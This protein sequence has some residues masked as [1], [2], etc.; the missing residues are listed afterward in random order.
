MRKE[1]GTTLNWISDLVMKNFGESQETK[2][3]ADKLKEIPNLPSDQVM[4][5]LKRVSD[6]IHKAK[7]GTY[8]A[9]KADS[10]TN[11][12]AKKIAAQ[13]YNDIQMGLQ[14]AMKAASQLSSSSR[15]DAGLYTNKTKGYVDKDGNFHATSVETIP[16][17]SFVHWLDKMMLFAEG[18]ITEA[19]FEKKPKPEGDPEKTGAHGDVFETEYGTYFVHKKT[20]SNRYHAHFVSSDF[21]NFNDLGDHMNRKDA[22][23]TMNQHHDKVAARGGKF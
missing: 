8:K 6:E 4:P 23:D 15:H 9:V 2:I 13:P 11:F 21:K 19:P 1:L 7:M 14:T 3:I 16:Q 5:S 18:K 17:E 12:G 20:D 22:I 10:P